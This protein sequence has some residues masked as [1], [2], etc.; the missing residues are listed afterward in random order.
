MDHTPNCKG[1]SANSKKLRTDEHSSRTSLT[2]LS[3]LLRNAQCAAE[4]SSLEYVMTLDV[5]DLCSMCSCENS[6]GLQSPLGAAEPT[7]GTL[8]V[9][10]SAEE[11]YKKGSCCWRCFALT[12]LAILGHFPVPSLSRSTQCTMPCLLQLQTNK[13]RL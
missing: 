2:G 11:L 12:S 5:M 6:G 1:T 10:C 13:R 8:L 7:T 9:Y 4:C 3:V